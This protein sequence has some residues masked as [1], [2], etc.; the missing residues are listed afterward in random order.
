MA[1][2]CTGMPEPLRRSLYP[3]LMSL[4][5]GLESLKWI[6]TKAARLAGRPDPFDNLHWCWWARFCVQ[7][8]SYHVCG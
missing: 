8:H 3:N 1:F 4:F 7:V 5:D 6:D 2:V